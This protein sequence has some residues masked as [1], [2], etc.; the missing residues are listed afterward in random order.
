MEEVA[1]KHKDKVEFLFLYCREA[2]P[3]GDPRVKTRTKDGKAIPQATTDKERREMAKAFCDDMKM[4]RRILVDEFDNKSVQRLY[5]GLPNPTLVIDVDGK[6]A[7]KMAWTNGEALDRY[8]EKFLAGGGKLD[9]ELAKSVPVSGPGGPGGPGPEGTARMVE[10]MLDGLELTE[11]E[12]KTVRAAVR[13]KVEARGRLSQQA[14]ELDELARNKKT[15]ETELAKAVKSFEA[16]V[17]DYQKTTAEV[18]RKLSDQIC[19]KTRA[20]LLARG[21]FE[22]SLGFVGPPARPP[23]PSPE[24]KKDNR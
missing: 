12:A 5:G 9:R 11:A 20:Q 4:T 13:S 18:D 2:H 6:M 22:T 23:M 16:A 1:K 8:L 17:A 21:V 15:T 3:D 7:L 10:R 14:R 19:A 24:E